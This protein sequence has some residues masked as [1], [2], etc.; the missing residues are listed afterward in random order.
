M[1]AWMSSVVSSSDLSGARSGA[2]LAAPGPRSPP[3][4]PAPRTKTPDVFVKTVSPEASVVVESIVT[5]APLPL[6]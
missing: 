1:A 4:P 2:L 5:R 6:S 3:K